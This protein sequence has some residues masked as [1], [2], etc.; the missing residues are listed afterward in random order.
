[1]PFIGGPLDGQPVD[2]GTLDQA[3]QGGMIDLASLA[4]GA[5]Q[6]AGPM[7]PGLG[8]APSPAS[9]GPM[10]NDPSSQDSPDSGSSS[11]SDSDRLDRIL[12]DML[13]VAGGGISEQ[14]K[15]RIQKA[16]TLVQDIKAAEEKDS[17]AALGGKLSP[18]MMAKAYGG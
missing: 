17:H 11:L 4:Q 8:P 12:S 16:M 13:A 18:K 10:P 14:D 7:P 3:H 6:G 5:G 2:P 9:S 1:M 15:A